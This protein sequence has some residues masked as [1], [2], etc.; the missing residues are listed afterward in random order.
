VVSAAT[1]GRGEVCIDSDGAIEYFAASSA[2]N[3]VDHITYGVTDGDL[4][5]TATVTVSVAGV[6][7]LRAQLVHRSS[8]R[9]KAQVRFT[10]GNNRTMVVLAG[11]PKKRKPLLTR[12][13]A[14]G[15]AVAF[16]TKYKKITFFA[17]VR[18]TD[19][20]AILV[21]IG[22]LNTRTGHQS[23]QTG[24][25]GFLRQHPSLRTLQRAWQRR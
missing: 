24:D 6:K 23:I 14:P 7:S 1:P 18:D 11:T 3:Y 21:D 17:F 9:K 25:A 16:K 4:Y 15:H 19:G 2:V 5:R 12:T 20:L 10:N 8:G 22:S 13:I